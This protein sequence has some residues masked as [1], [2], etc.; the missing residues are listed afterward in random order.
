M[1]RIPVESSDIVSIGYD[2]QAR[3]LEIE[4]Q[5]ERTYQ[6]QDVA[7]E[8]HAQFMRADS[9]GQFFS[10]FINRRYRYKK[11]EDDARQA[12]TSGLLAFVTGNAI[13]FGHMQEAC[14]QFDIQVEQLDLPVDEIQSDDPED[15]AVKKAKLA[16]KLAGRPV[17]VN[18]SFWNILALRG[19]PGAYM[20]A[21]DRWLRPEDFLK[22]MEGKN[23]RDIVLTD[24]VAYH[25]G[26]RTKVFSREHHGII[27][28]EP[29]GGSESSIGQ[30]VVLDGQTQ[31]ITEV[32][33]TGGY[34]IEIKDS[35]FYQF[36][37]W[38]NMHRRIGR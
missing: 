33:Q 37:K 27:I 11:V 28:D 15:I 36:A 24:T 25:D 6:Y 9:F 19:F 23:D 4:F 21:V 2:E 32:W 3:T 17:V 38:F 8:T 12:D 13:K 29:R 35:S 30:V 16:F 7:P 18:D 14:A 26:K 34:N 1:H 10:T 22:L 20:N 5:N 31:T